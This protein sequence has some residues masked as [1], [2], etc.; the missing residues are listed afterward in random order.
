ML[1]GPVAEEVEY[2]RWYGQLEVTVR[3]IVNGGL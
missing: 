2:S 1:Y 3:N